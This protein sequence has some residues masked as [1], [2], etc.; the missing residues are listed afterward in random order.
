MQRGHHVARRQVLDRRRVA[1]HEALVLGVAQDAAL[2]AGRLRQEDA[3]LVDAGRVELEEL[4]VLHGDAPPV[5]Q[6]RPVAGERVGVGGDLEHLAEA[7]GGEEHALGVEDVQVAG[8][9]L[10]G[11]H[12]RR[13]RPSTN[14][15]SR[16]W[17]SLKKLTPRATH[18]WKSVCR[19]M[20][21][22]RS[23]E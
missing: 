3:E 20:W 7:A 12:R 14:A 17:N 4:H 13:P 9:L 15:M 19:I 6:A 8:G 5:E 1:L 11:D 23:A 2:A 22:V 21:P 18:C 16:T 10:V